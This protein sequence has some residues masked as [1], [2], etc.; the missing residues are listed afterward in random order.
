M[1][2]VPPAPGWTERPR[3]G[4]HSR[5]RAAA[6]IA[7]RARAR[8]RGEGG[9]GAVRAWAAARRRLRLRGAAAAAA[10]AAAAPIAGW[11]CRLGGRARGGGGGA[12]GSIGTQHSTLLC[13][14]CECN[15]VLWC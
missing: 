2:E 12:I 4:H 11:V 10:A 13:A 9:R 15:C 1:Q 3:R 7:S 14:C 5:R 6:G 8:A